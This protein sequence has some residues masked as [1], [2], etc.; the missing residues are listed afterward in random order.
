MGDRFGRLVTVERLNNGHGRTRW[1]CRCDCGNTSVPS[2]NNLRRT[3][4]CGCLK[5]ERTASRSTKHGS[6]PRFHPTPTYRVWTDMRKRCGLTFTQAK[7]YALRGITVCERWND[8]SVFLADMG[9]QPVGMSIDRIDN[10]K[11]YSP[12]NCRWAT[13]VE[14]NNN[15]RSNRLITWDGKTRTVRQWERELGW[16]HDSLKSRLH[17]WPIERAFTQPFGTRIHGG[18]RCQPPGL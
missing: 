15:K 10:D 18:A 11:G 8:F 6:S 13:R 2:E 9:E 1:L 4:S 7:D 3:R 17:R 12:D 5:R 14:Q 16:R